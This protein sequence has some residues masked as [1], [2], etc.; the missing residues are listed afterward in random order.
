MEPID[1]QFD[2]PG[3]RFWMLMSLL[4]RPIHEQEAK[5]RLSGAGHLDKEDV[6][7]DTLRKLLGLLAESYSGWFDSFAPS[8][9]CSAAL[10]EEVDRMFKESAEGVQDHFSRE[11]FR[12]GAR[13][14]RLRFFAGNVLKEAGLPPRDVPSY[15]DFE[16]LI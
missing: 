6:A 4:C 13:W 14:E 5:L 15:I 16:A 12:T 10:Q 1:E 2:L 7:S 11:S 3:E 9:A 8:V